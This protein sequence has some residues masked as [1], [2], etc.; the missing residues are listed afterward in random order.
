QFGLAQFPVNRWRLAKMSNLRPA[1]L[2]LP[3]GEV[4]KV[5]VSPFSIGRHPA[6]ALVIPQTNVSRHHAELRW[7]EG[8][9]NVMD[10][11]SLNGVFVNK[12]RISA[13]ELEDGD[14]LRIGVVPL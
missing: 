11:G 8:R 6:K 9:W 14:E 12:E 13:G 10:T 4:R 2:R 3:N 7:A 1:E 5:D